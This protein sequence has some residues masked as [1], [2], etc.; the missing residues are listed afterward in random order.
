MSVVLAN[1][2]HEQEATGAVAI[3]RDLMGTVWRKGVTLA[4]VKQDLLGR[5]EHLN[6]YGAFDA[7]RSVRDNR[8]VVPGNN[9]A[10]CERALLNSYVGT[11]GDPV[12]LAS[13]NVGFGHSHLPGSLGFEGG[14]A[15]RV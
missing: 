8:V 7:V 5:A 4:H 13:T 11:L 2:L 12:D 15:P 14:V 10:W 3:G 1:S 9:L 6:L